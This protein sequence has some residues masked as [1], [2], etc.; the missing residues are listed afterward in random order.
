MKK[1]GGWA[2][3]GEKERET[4]SQQAI[5]NAEA[6]QQERGIGMRLHVLS[7]KLILAETCLR[8]VRID[9]S[10]YAAAPT[11]VSSGVTPPALAA[12]NL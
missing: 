10:G 12:Q 11:Q 1:G 2:G 3:E 4:L 9:S 5:I 8:Q 6:V 7:G